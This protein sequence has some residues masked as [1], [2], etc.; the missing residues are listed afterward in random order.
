M[1]KKPYSWCKVERGDIV[2]FRYKGSD[3]T[4]CS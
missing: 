1:A 2:S 3:Y 4:F